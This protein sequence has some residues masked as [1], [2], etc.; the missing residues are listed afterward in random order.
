MCLLQHWGHLAFGVF[1]ITCTGEKK[2]LKDFGP[3][4]KQ[5]FTIGSLFKS[6]KTTPN[7][8]KR[9]GLDFFA[10]GLVFLTLG[11]IFIDVDDVKSWLFHY[12]FDEEDLII[13]IPLL[14]LISFIYYWPLKKIYQVSNVIFLRFLQILRILIFWILLVLYGVT[15]FNYFD[16][17]YLREN[18]DSFYNDYSPSNAIEEAEPATNDNFKSTKGSS[19]SSPNVFTKFK[20]QNKVVHQDVVFKGGFI[21][22]EKAGIIP[23]HLL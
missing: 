12:Y 23:I 15:T 4:W 1:I 21:D 7:I 9:G 8:K 19:K 6:T 5:Y 13:L 17:Y 20:Q 3:L 2:V 22:T 10:S 11:W 14:S 16:I 18:N